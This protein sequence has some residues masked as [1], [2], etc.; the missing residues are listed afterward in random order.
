MPRTVTK[1]KPDL[2]KNSDKN[3]ETVNGRTIE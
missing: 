3:H 2:R 1:Y